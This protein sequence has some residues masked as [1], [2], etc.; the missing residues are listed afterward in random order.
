MYPRKAA[1]KDA[2]MSPEGRGSHRIVMDSGIG[3]FI[4][5]DGFVWEA[6]A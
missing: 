6:T 3:S 4:D 2:G 5:P 1:A